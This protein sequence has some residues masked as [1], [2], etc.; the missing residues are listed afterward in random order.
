MESLWN[1]EQP[2]SKEIFFQKYGLANEQTAEEI[3]RGV[4][5]SAQDSRWGDL[6]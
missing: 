3:F 2:I 6:P 4:A 5:A 1:W